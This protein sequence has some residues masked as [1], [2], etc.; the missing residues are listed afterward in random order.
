MDKTLVL[1][2][3]EDRLLHEYARRTFQLLTGGSSSYF[4][5]PYLSSYLEANILKEV[6]KDRLI[7]NQAAAAFAAGQPL[8]SMNIEEL[9]ERTKTIDKA[10]VEQSVIPSLAITVHYEDFA[11]IRKARISRVAGIVYDLLGRWADE[12]HLADVVRTTYSSSQFCDRLFDVLHLYNLETRQLGNSIH[13]FPPFSHALDNFAEE[14]YE[15]ME[16]A[17][18]ELTKQYCDAIYRREAA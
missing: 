15:V 12:I 14:L 10:F 11:D 8:S 3:A 5:L 18:G 1:G 9:F 17:A 6:E 16:Q 2:N 4:H 13:L 7:I